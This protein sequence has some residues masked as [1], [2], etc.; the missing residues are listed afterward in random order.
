MKK[1]LYILF[2]GF[3]MN[4]ISNW[5]DKP[6]HFLRKLSKK[7]NIFVYQNK[8]IE[9]DNTYDLS[10][11]TAKGF[12]KDVYFSLLQEIPN[13]FDFD[14][15][16]IGFSFGGILAYIFAILYKKYCKY[17]VL[18]DNPPY[19][20]M[21]SNIYRIKMIEKNLL[22]EKW[23]KLTKEKFEMIK[24]KNPNYLL[25]YGV[26]SFVKYL[27]N[28]IIKKKLMETVPIYGFY[29]VYDPDVYQKEFEKTHNT[30]LFDEINELKKLKNFHYNLYTNVGHMIYLNKKACKVILDKI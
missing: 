20:T 7:G 28:N 16:P 17:C 10:Y 12:M 14:W 13:A 23:K 4:S 3:G 27:Q 22:Q 2:Q 26:I 25:D 19:F 6:T 15:I 8:W 9:Q 21:K 24:I 11:L 30:Q 29:N 1:K 5:N 18:I